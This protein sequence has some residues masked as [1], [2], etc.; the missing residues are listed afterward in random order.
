MKKR[1]IKYLSIVLVIIFISISFFG[2]STNDKENSLPPVTLSIVVANRSNTIAAVNATVVNEKLYEAAISY[3]SISI[4]EEDGAPYIVDS[5]DINEPSKSGLS[6]NKKEQIAKDQRAQ[7]LEIICNSAIPKCAEADTL[8]A[9]MKAGREL[10]SSSSSDNKQLVILSNGLSTTGVLNFSKYNYLNSEPENVITQ[11]ESMGEIPNLN[12]VDVFWI[13]LGETTY[14]Q[15]SLTNKNRNTLQT[16]WSGILE[17]AGAN[18]VKFYSDNISGINTINDSYPMVS[19]VNVINEE[20]KMDENSICV[21]DEERLNFKPSSTEFVN[22]KTAIKALEPVAEYMISNPDYSILLAGTTA[23]VGSNDWCR[24]FSLRRAGVVKKV[25]V[26]M[27][28]D[29]SRIKIVGLGYDGHCFHVNDIDK[30]GNLI[31]EEAKK[32]RA[33]IIMNL[34]SEQAQNLLT[35]FTG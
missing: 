11:V 6:E 19:T 27:G 5:F 30:N 24:E 14:P 1:I 32:N 16:I 22:T 21:Y 33:V 17:I 29:S 25:I 28:V 2:C 15:Q 31:A 35:E 34:N 18:S 20:V 9:L 26:D 10:H 12:G 13:G 7:L 4:I 8:Q 23:T 3:G